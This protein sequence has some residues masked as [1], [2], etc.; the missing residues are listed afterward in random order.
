[1]PPHVRLRLIWPERPLKLGRFDFD[2]GR[3][4][5]ALSMPHVERVLEPTERA[6]ESTGTRA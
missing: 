6:S 3:I 5:D 1:V 4:E 2:H